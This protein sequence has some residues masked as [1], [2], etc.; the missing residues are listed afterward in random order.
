MAADQEA[1]GRLAAF[2]NLGNQFVVSPES[3]GHKQLAVGME[4]WARQS[5]LPATP[6]TLPPVPR[7]LNANQKSKK[8]R[9]RCLSLSWILLTSVVYFANTI[10]SCRT[11][12]APMMSTS[13]FT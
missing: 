6:S 2:H 8:G 3:G 10:A 12:S 4:E 13:F 5:R 9:R 1:P 7:R 11:F